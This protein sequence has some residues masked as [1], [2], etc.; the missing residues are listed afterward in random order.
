M[1]YYRNNIIHLFVIPALL[2]KLISLH[3]KISQQCLSDAV[4]VIYPFLKEDLILHW[5]EDQLNSY[6][7]QCLNTFSDCG[8]I[9]Y[10]ESQWSISADNPDALALDSFSSVVLPSLER[11]AMLSQILFKAGSGELKQAG[12]EKHY[13]KVLKGILQLLGNGDA[14]HSDRALIKGFIKTLKSTG[15]VEMNDER[16]LMFDGNFE[17]TISDLV[18]VISPEV[19][20][21]IDEIVAE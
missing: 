15:A 7:G 1:G 3:G 8:F 14:D 20:Q 9:Q 19:H 18:L 4:A 10:E 16:Q 5:D 13:F 2:I 17:Q 21:I 12:L 11:Y 6:I